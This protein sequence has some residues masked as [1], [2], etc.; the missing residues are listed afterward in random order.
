[1]ERSRGTG[2]GT[3]WSY[4]QLLHLLH[5]HRH[6]AGLL[7]DQPDQ[8]SP[9]KS[10]AEQRQV[11]TRGA[12]QGQRVG[13]HEWT[14]FLERLGGG[15]GVGPAPRVRVRGKQG[16]L[17]DSQSGPGAA[18]CCHAHPGGSPWR[19]T[20]WGPASS[21]RQQERSPGGRSPPPSTSPASGGHT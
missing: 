12:K 10:G 1:M 9:D 16:L 11:T 17:T 15:L 8:A 18:Q 3:T 14:P 4:S 2:R 7:R 5:A 21:H 6:A 13:L 19:R 20:G